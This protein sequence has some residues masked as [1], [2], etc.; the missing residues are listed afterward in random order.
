GHQNFTVG[1]EIYHC[2]YDPN[3]ESRACS[4]GPMG[5][6]ALVEQAANRFAKHLL[7]PEDAI[8]KH[9]RMRGMGDTALVL[10]DI[11]SLEQ[12]FGVSRQ[13]MCWRLEELHKITQAES[14]QYR[15]NVKQSARALGK[16]TKL[17]TETNESIIISDYVERA[18]EAL[19]KDLITEARYEEI[20]ADADLLEAIVGAEAEVDVV[21]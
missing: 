8:Y 3:L 10:A 9:L 19:S 20:L 21:D 15:Q 2:L 6:G 17:Y 13:A 5:R 16:D 7:M 1:H 18:K 12:F 14:D 11:I 4:I